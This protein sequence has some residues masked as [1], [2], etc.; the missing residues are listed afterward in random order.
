MRSIFE[1]HLAVLEEVVE[2]RHDAPLGLLD[3][4]DNEDAAMLDSAHGGTVD[5]CECAPRKERAALL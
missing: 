1:V 4:L 3:A 2:H 5:I